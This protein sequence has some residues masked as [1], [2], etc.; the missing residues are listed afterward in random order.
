MLARQAPRNRILQ[1]LTIPDKT[2]ASSLITD[3]H[4]HIQPFEFLLNPPALE[5]MKKHRPDF[6]QVLEFTR[7]PKAF[8]NYMDKV[9]LDAQC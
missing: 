3:C 2:R 9:G 4:V 1:P 8:L 5:L 6:D 7:S